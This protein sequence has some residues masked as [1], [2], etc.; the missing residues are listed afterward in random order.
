MRRDQERIEVRE[1]S[2]YEPKFFKVYNHIVERYARRVGFQA[3]GVY[4]TLKQFSDWNNPTASKCTVSQ[5]RIA[6]TWGCTSRTV[7]R[8]VRKLRDF[9]LIRVK[10]NQASST[11]TILKIPV[12]RNTIRHDKSVASDT[13][14]M[15][16]QTRH[17]SRI[18]QILFTRGADVD[19]SSRGKHSRT[20]HK[21][22]PSHGFTQKDFDQ[23]DYRKLMAALKTYE[24]EASTTAGM[25]KEEMDARFLR[26]VRNAAADAGLLPFRAAQLLKQVYP[27]DPLMDQIVPKKRKKA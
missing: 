4:C 6:I 17:A 21:K 16:L 12:P 20:G 3:W 10:K 26:N 1:Q 2:Y 18:D 23:R 15:S 8:A 22:H 25:G 13:S 19:K 14:Q 9:G 11:Y 27:N 7:Q 24:G 5:A